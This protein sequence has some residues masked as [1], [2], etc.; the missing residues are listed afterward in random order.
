MPREVVAV[1]DAIG[2]RVRTEILRLLAATPMT[3][4]DLA[5]ETGGDVTRVRRHLAVLEERGLVY[6]DRPPEERG[7]GRGRSVLWRTDRARAEEAGR[8][9]ID[10]VTGT[11]APE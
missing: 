11:Y 10:Y 3:A 1:I 9:W 8:L 2:N 7:P 5:K 4:G 6:A